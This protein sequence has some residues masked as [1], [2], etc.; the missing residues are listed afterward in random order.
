MMVVRDI[1]VNRGESVPMPGGIRGVVDLGRVALR[2]RRGHA[3]LIYSNV[4]LVKKPHVGIIDSRG[5]PNDFLGNF[6]LATE[7]SCLDA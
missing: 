6:S 4:C 5:V 1:K 2:Y 7:I 3:N